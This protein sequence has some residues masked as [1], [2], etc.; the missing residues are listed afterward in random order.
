MASAPFR[1]TLL[2]DGSS[3]RVL[4]RPIEW[5]LQH[6]PRVQRDGFVRQFYAARPPR[7]L[8]AGIEHACAEFPCDLLFVHRDAEGAAPDARVAEIR[9]AAAR[10]TSPSWVPVVPVRMTE[11]W[12]L[13]DEAAIRGAAG[14]PRGAVPLELPPLGRLEVVPDP[15]ALLREL[16][17]RAS[18]ARGRHL[19][20]IRRDLPARIHRVAAL[21]DDFAPL[22][23]LGAF[24]RF[25]AETRAALGLPVP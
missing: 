18:E 3:D 10:A 20:R 9:E 5:V 16:L 13:I 22:R 6:V 12:L 11:A 21:I 8:A 14:N 4:C 15:R 17:V 7:D 25:E 24:C 2:A 23:S 19:R 1:Y